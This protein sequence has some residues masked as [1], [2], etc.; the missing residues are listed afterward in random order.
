[1]LE[2]LLL[3]LA[4][5]P[6]SLT[7]EDLPHPAEK[8][9]LDIA[10][11]FGNKHMQL[12]LACEARDDPL[13]VTIDTKICDAFMEKL[14]GLES[15]VSSG[16]I[17][18]IRLIGEAVQKWE[19]RFNYGI[20]VMEL[21]LA[22][23]ALELRKHQ[24]EYSGFSD[25]L[26]ITESCIVAIDSVW[27]E[28]M[29]NLLVWGQGQTNSNVLMSHPCI[30]DC[31]SLISDIYDC[32]GQILSSRRLVDDLNTLE[33]F[34][35]NHA[36]FKALKIP[37]CSEDIMDTL[38]KI[39][40]AMWSFVFRT[41]PIEDLFSVL[42]KI[43]L[44]GSGSWAEYLGNSIES[45]PKVLQ[46]YYEDFHEIPDT[47]MALAEDCLQWNVDDI[48]TEL[49]FGQSE[50]G[51]AIKLRWPLNLAVDSRQCRI[52]GHIHNVLSSLAAVR[53]RLLSRTGW[54]P[55]IYRVYLN[56]IWGWVQSRFE[57][58]FEKIKAVSMSHEPP[59]AREIHTETLS[60]LAADSFLGEK[61]LREALYD[62]LRGALASELAALHEFKK[63]LATNS[64]FDT[65]VLQLP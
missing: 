6:T 47:A 3:V 9:I 42:R 30:N 35:R 57:W 11:R 14:C 24:E 4:G 49:V 65:L 56:I 59:L 21:S 7:S 62:L 45:P 36:E 13:S 32:S 58:H 18:I 17:H 43:V 37:L 22:S 63:Q 31:K 34:E 60:Q 29:A 46:L 27:K 28:D 16:K 25:I 61:A 10:S 12:K 15:E 64:R 1:M 5:L 40:G 2:E 48:F 55:F 39:R 20:Q 51:L 54:T 38:S 50:R 26:P 8:Q 44:V 53:V 52:Y 41:E 23:A 19:R 33:L